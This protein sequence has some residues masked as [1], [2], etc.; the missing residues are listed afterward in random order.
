MKKRRGL[1]LRRWAA[2]NGQGSPKL[3]GT[4]HARRRARLG[5]LPSV[6][7]G[8]LLPLLAASPSVGVAGQ[9]LVRVAWGTT[10]SQQRRYFG[11]ISVDRGQISGLQRL[12]TSPDSP[13]ALQLSGGRVLINPRVPR[14]FDGCDLVVDAEES[15]ALEFNF[16]LQG[17][18]N[19]KTFTVPFADLRSGPYTTALDTQGGHLI[20]QRAPGA[21]L[22][23]EFARSSLVFAPNERFDF[24]MSPDIPGLEPGHSMQIEVVVSTTGS[25]VPLSTQ[26]F[27]ATVEEN[28]RTAPQSVEVDV[29]GLE[30]AYTIS[31]TASRALG[32]SQKILPL[33]RP[34][35]ASREIEIAVVDPEAQVAELTEEWQEVLAVDPANSRWWSRLPEWTR[36]HRLPGIRA[37]TLEN[38]R[39]V[40]RD[41]PAGTLVELPPAA[42]GEPAWRAF[43]LPVKHPGRPHRLVINTPEDNAQSLAVSIIERDAANRAIRLGRD[44]LLVQEDAR[45][46]AEQQAETIT[47]WPRTDAPVVLIANPH[48]DNPA[49]FGSIRLQQQPMGP[50]VKVSTKPLFDDQRLLAYYA[51]SPAVFDSLGDEELVDPVSRLALDGWGSFLTGATRAAQSLKHAGYNSLILVVAADGGSLYPSDLIGPSPVFDSGLLASTGR[52][53]IQKDVLEMLLRVCDREGIRLVPM[54]DLSSPWAAELSAANRESLAHQAGATSAFSHNEQY[55]GGKPPTFVGDSTSAL[56]L[57]LIQRYRSHPSLGGVGIKLFSADA[58]GNGYRLPDQGLL[59]TSARGQSNTPEAKHLS[60]EVLKRLAADIRLARDDLSLVLDTSSVIDWPQ[61]SMAVRDAVISHSSAKKALSENGVEPEVWSRIPN[62]IVLKPQLIAPADLSGYTAVRGRWSKLACDPWASSPQPGLWTLFGSTPLALPSFG[63]QGPFKE[64]SSNYRVQLQ[65]RPAGADARKH[66]V[67]AVADG[68][69]EAIVEGGET[70]LLAGCGQASN[71]LKLLSQLPPAHTEVR[72][73]RSQPLTVRVYRQ[74]D[75]TTVCVAN[76]SPWPCTATLPLESP[77]PIAWK[78]LGSLGSIPGR[79]DRVDP[80]GGRTPSGA[81]SWSLL[82]PA[83]GIRAWEFSSQRVRIGVPQIERSE[84]EIA[85]LSDQI[86]ELEARTRNLDF[87]PLV[88]SVPNSGFEQSDAI[89][90]PAGWRPTVGVRGHAIVDRSRQR[91]GA[92]SLYLRSYNDLGVA[93]VSSE[94]PA[95]PTGQLVVGAYVQSQPSDIAGAELLVS[96]ASDR[97]EQEFF[98]ESLLATLKQPSNDWQRV[99]VEVPAVPLPRDATLKL[100]F[101]LKGRGEVW[102]DDV[103]LSTLSISSARRVEFVKRL[104]AAKEALAEGNVT[105]CRRLLDDYWSRRVVQHIPPWSGEKTRVAIREAESEEPPNTKDSPL[106]DRLRG[107]VPRILR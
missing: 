27:D 51:A 72:I 100:Q 31:V 94:V 105:D 30:G 17:S 60:E 2:M 11:S 91:S 50:S 14:A 48:P 56:V 16:R 1:R 98:A 8:L 44:V 40:I 13:V 4:W 55:E 47:F 54:I 22:P 97:K 52:D 64:L 67:H 103:E 26:A 21:D 32:F 82:L 69:F 25:D 88:E 9:E 65:T 73:E 18:S 107:F 3:S 85:D 35:V 57:E 45:A 61:G 62:C 70:G 74:E 95:P 71:S 68:E 106:G 84:E 63:V 58:S 28:G 43:I 53:P 10:D 76:D 104:Y 93:V 6:A 90:A 38:V 102:I 39:P 78:S 15:S 59:T 89:G 96:V 66:I 83:Y 42:H 87:R 20:V 12:G 77:E 49:Q 33:R 24:T 86:A 92:A 29:P 75:V 34:V 7:I 23:I 80:E 37:G 36:S 99:E 79:S 19:D 41:H 101:H 5:I 81:S 46:T